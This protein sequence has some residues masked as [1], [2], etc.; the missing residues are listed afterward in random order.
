[1]CHAEGLKLEGIRVLWHT[2][3]RELLRYDGGAT[4]VRASFMLKFIKN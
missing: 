2:S 1:M 4:C 3:L